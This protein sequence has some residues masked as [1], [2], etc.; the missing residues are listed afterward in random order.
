MTPGTSPRPLGTPFMRWTAAAK[1]I[2]GALARLRVDATISARGPEL[3]RAAAILYLAALASS[4]RPPGTPPVAG[5]GTIAAFR[6]GTW[7]S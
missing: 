6:H 1:G 5:G 4:S 7:R 3:G 2:Y